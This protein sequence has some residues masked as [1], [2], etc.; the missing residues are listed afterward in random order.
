MKYMVFVSLSLVGRHADF[1]LSRSKADW[2]PEEVV[3]PS[4][5]VRTASDLMWN[6][7]RVHV[8][9]RWLQLDLFRIHICAHREIPTS[10]SEENSH[11]TFSSCARSYESG[12]TI[13]GG[14]N[15]DWTSSLGVD[16]AKRVCQFLNP[17]QWWFSWHKIQKTLEK[18]STQGRGKTHYFRWAKL[19]SGW[20]D[21]LYVQCK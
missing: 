15:W 17:A 11:S 20:I 8:S 14:W 13:Y 10:A 7:P 9:W 4:S 3:M 19:Y 6:G 5:N 1:Q 12:L 21:K 18:L 2:L 16:M